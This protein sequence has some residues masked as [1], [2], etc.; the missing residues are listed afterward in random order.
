MGERVV[1]RGAGGRLGMSPGWGP[2]RH[3][4]KD[5]PARNQYPHPATPVPSPVPAR[6]T[7]LG[8][9]WRNRPWR[10]VD[11]VVWTCVVAWALLDIVTTTVGL[12][13]GAAAEG[14]RLGAAAYDS[15]GAIGLLVVKSAVLFGIMLV[16]VAV[17]WQWRRYVRAGTLAGGTVTLAAV[18]HN[19]WLLLSIA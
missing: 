5:A 7:T 4:P 8:N 12:A 10:A 3:T 18:A 14:N 11:L 17:P 1:D 16:W 2:P 19:T 13:S 6:W 9:R 15:G